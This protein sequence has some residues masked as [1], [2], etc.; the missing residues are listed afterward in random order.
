M[1]DISGISLHNKSNKWINRNVNDLCNF[2]SLLNDAKLSLL[3]LFEQITMSINP[4]NDWHPCSNQISCDSGSYRDTP[5][6]SWYYKSDL[7]QTD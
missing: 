6:S 2:I 7:N 5:D 1:C 3:L 4:S